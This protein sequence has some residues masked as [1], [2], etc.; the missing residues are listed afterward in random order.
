MVHSH[1]SEGVRRVLGTLPPLLLFSVAVGWSLV[2]SQLQGQINTRQ[3]CLGLRFLNAHTCLYMHTLAH[4]GVF[5]SVFSE[6]A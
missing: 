4:T 1:C 5:L 2:K 3:V 6:L